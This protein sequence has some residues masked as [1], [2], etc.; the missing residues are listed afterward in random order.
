MRPRPGAASSGAAAREAGKRRAVTRL[1]F[2]G[3]FHRNERKFHKTIDKSKYACYNTTRTLRI[4][5]YKLQVRMLCI[6]LHRISDAANGAWRRIPN[7]SWALKGL[8]ER[9]FAMSRTIQK[10]IIYKSCYSD[11]NRSNFL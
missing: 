4:H 6:R 3:H 7:V 8:L 11:M 5:I 10:K 1:R 2:R 9:Y